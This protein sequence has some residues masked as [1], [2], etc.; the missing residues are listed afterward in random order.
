[1]IS[2]ALTLLAL[3]TFAVIGGQERF[4]PRQL[5]AICIGIAGVLMLFGPVAVA[6]T[7]DLWEMRGSLDN[8]HRSISGV[9]A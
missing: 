1:V 2:S 8:L 5:G 3:P 9:S 4:S 6:G 7:L